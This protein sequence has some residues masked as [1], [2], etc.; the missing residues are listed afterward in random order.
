MEKAFDPE[1]IS[2]FQMKMSA[3]VFAFSNLIFYFH[4]NSSTS[5]I[6]FVILRTYLH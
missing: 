4:L 3:R 6:S 5:F 1:G 2:G